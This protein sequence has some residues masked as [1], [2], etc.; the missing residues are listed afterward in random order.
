[1][2]F[3]KI[4]D[5]VHSINLPY[6]DSLLAWQKAK[7]HCGAPRFIVPNFPFRLDQPTGAASCL[8]SFSNHKTFARA[9]QAGTGRE[10]NHRTWQI[11]IVAQKDCERIAVCSAAQAGPTCNASLIWLDR[12]KRRSISFEGVLRCFS[13]TALKFQLTSEWPSR[14]AR[15]WVK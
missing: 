14:G 12:H 11:S 13:G 15:W 8:F 3:S 10:Q 2:Q 7:S 4:L 1:M 9:R 6:L 5:S